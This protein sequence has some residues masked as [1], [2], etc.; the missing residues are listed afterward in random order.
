M[1]EVFVDEDGGEQR[2]LNWSKESLIAKIKE[3]ILPQVIVSCEKSAGLFL[4]RQISVFDD[5]RPS[6]FFDLLEDGAITLDHLISRSEPSGAVTEKGPLF[7]IRNS[8]RSRL[9]DSNR[10][11]DWC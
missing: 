5:P 7:K 10:I 3:K 1:W 9:Y 6:R 8:A 11:V 2:L 4:V